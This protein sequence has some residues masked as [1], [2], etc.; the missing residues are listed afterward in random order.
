MISI[1]FR[2]ERLNEEWA[3]RNNGQSLAQLAERGGLS[4]IEAAAIAQRRPF[5][6]I[7]RDAAWAVFKEPLTNRPGLKHT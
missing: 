2:Q 4:L 5:T 6:V 3:Q 1:T 7:S